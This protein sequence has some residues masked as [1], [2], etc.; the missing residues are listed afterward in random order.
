MYATQFKQ[1]QCAMHS[2]N[3]SI[4]GT[5]MFSRSLRGKHELHFLEEW[6]MGAARWAANLARAPFL[7]Q[8]QTFVMP[9]EQSG[10]RQIVEYMTLYSSWDSAGLEHSS[11][12]A[13]N[14]PMPATA[15]VVDHETL[16]MMHGHSISLH[17]A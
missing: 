17:R 5:R 15:N 8:Q 12:Q 11:L 13:T 2:L 16:R 3:A 9:V 10:R 7:G 1:L 4:V 14:G 6:H